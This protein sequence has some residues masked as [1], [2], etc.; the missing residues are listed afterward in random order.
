MPPRRSRLLPREN[1]KA[2]E[3]ISWEQV[4]READA[5]DFTNPFL[6]NFALEPW[7]HTK[8]CTRPGLFDPLLENL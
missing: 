1:E 2:P 6:E 5:F 8:N 3:R 7:W 4:R